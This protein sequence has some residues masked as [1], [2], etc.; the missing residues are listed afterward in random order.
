MIR[1][2]TRMRCADCH[3][4]DIGL[5]PV[6]SGRQRRYVCGSCAE[7]DRAAVLAE[8]RHVL[9][10][11]VAQERFEELSAEI[12]AL[13]A[14]AKPQRRRGYLSAEIEPEPEPKALEEGFRWWE[15]EPDS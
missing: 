1:R 11:V 12:E 10:P 2:D 9:G 14:S 7:K 8:G 6:M 13:K 15:V 5:V 3:E 4:R